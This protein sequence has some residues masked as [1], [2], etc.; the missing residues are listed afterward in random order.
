MCLL[1]HFTRFCPTFCLYLP[2]I[3]MIHTHIYNPQWHIGDRD[4]V[5]LES[6]LVTQLLAGS[7]LGSPTRSVLMVLAGP[8]DPPPP[9]P[10]S[11]PSSTSPYPF[12]Y[13][14]PPL[15]TI[16]GHQPPLSLAQDYTP[17]RLVWSRLKER[18]G[19]EDRRSEPAP[20]P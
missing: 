1:R 2:H 19:R 6:D 5:G 11:F 10:P 16:W 14:P 20:L 12:T 4:A 3:N 8:P 9:P 18:G 13:K 15:P 17:A 7:G